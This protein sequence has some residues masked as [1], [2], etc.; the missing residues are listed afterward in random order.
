VRP[1]RI[2]ALAF[3]DDERLSVA[4]IGID[5]KAKRRVLSTGGADAADSLAACCGELL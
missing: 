5:S 3:E 1:V 2:D 4:A